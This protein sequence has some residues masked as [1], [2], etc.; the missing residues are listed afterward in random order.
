MRVI[1]FGT[2]NYV[3]PILDAL[4]KAFKSKSGES[5]VVAV[6]T[7][8][9]KPIGRKK[10]IEY[11]AVD[12][13][14]RKIGVKVLSRLDT[15][16]MPNADVGVLASYGGIIPTVI[17]DH[18]KFG[19]LNVHPS[20]LPK[21]R[22]ASPV[23]A[24]LIAGE[25]ETGVS[26]IKLD[27][28]LDHGPIVAQFKKEILDN[29]TTET[30]RDRSFEKSAEVLIAL[31]PSYMK[32]KII[33]RKQ[34]HKNATFTRQITKQDAFVPPKYLRHTLQG[35]TFKGKW[36][37]P[38][39]KNYSLVP[40]PHSLERF[41]RAMQPWPISWTNVQLNS[42]SKIQKSKLYI[43]RLKILKAHTEP[44]R[45]NPQVSQR[46]PVTNHRSPITDHKLVFDEVQLEGKNPV[47]WKQFEE[48]YP[49][50]EFSEQ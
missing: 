37:I 18:C 9:P 14:A 17:I 33:S 26:I 39:I 2:P 24:A 32:G 50:F 19:I 43:K 23:P 1:F 7:Q 41:I 42:K 35:G 29:D 3:I 48:G 49:N 40:S 44:V 36:K 20:L 22:G 21:Y 8:K 34:D 28:E 13:W 5:P 30:L 46:K 6:V 15:K 47:S 4:H 11:S 38:F 27:S 45:I 25:K 12:K 16:T 31:L 10:V